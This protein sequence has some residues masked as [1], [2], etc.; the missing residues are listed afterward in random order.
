MAQ[1]KFTRSTQPIL[2]CEAVTERL[3]N[4]EALARH[5]GEWGLWDIKELFL[6]THKKTTNRPTQ[7]QRREYEWVC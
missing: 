3:V 4:P 2:K 6:H 1:G 5:G 7:S